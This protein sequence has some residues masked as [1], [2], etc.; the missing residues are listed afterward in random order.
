[1]SGGHNAAHEQQRG[2]ST[3]R[4]ERVPS[5]SGQPPCTKLHTYQTNTQHTT[6]EIE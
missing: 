3:A 6:V 5:S 2:G 4:K 1:V